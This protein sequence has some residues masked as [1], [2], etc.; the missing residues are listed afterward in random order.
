ML[1]LLSE[2]FLG[3]PSCSCNAGERWQWFSTL[4][5]NGA[6]CQRS[7]TIEDRA[8]ARRT[9]MVSDAPSQEVEESLSKT[10]ENAR[11]GRADSL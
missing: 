2:G 7:K 1:V 9:E 3:N 11:I 4:S 10:E 8:P 5:C 6:F